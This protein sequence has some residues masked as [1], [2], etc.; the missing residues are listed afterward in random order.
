MPTTASPAQIR[1]DFDAMA[2]LMPERLGPHEAWLLR[3]LPA[4][5]ERAL[6]LG[7]GAGTMARRM[8]ESFAHVDAIDFSPAMIAEANRRAP[9]S[10]H[11]ACADLFDWLH[12][13]PDTYDC[14]VTI[15]TLHHVDLGAALRAMASSLKAGGRLLALDV[16]ARRNVVVNAVA[17]A[18]GFR[19]TNWKLRQAFWRHG[20]N[21]TYLT[22]EE[23]RRVAV[24]ALPGASVRAHLLWRYSIVW[25]KP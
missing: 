7:C 3:Q 5:R 25:D 21:E 19:P 6:E 10:V 22:I 1:D 23:A 16:M 11:F 13:H 8:A 18:A 12:D 9:S 4:R 20:R 2:P 17:F 24:E 14:I 15:S